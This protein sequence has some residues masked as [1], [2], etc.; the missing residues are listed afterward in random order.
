MSNA[1]TKLDLVQDLVDE[2]QGISGSGPSSTVN[3]TGQYG[4]AVKWIDRAYLDVQRS[5]STWLFLRMQFAAAVPIQ[6]E[7]QGYYTAADLG[8][9]N[10]GQWIVNESGRE[11]DMRVYEAETAA[12]VLGDTLPFVLGAGEDDNYIGLGIDG[13]LPLV[14]VPWDTFRDLY[15][16]GSSRS[17]SGWPQV[18]TVAPNNAIVMHPRPDKEYVLVGEYYRTPHRFGE[19]DADVDTDTPIFP[20]AYHDII[21]FRALMYYATRY[22][23]PDILAEAEHEYKSIKNAMELTQLPKPVW[24]PPLV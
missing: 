22:A 21:M 2:A 20:E 1:K 16:L 9:T 6:D 17:I 4:R 7:N 8:L 3:Q 15:L 11:S 18:Y 23:E 5:R 19:N 12:S 24:G 13:E 10:V 14:Y